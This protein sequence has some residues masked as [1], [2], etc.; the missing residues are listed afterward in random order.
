MKTREINFHEEISCPIAVEL[1]IKILGL[2]NVSNELKHNLKLWGEVSGD[3]GDRFSIDFK[4]EHYY[5]GYCYFIKTI[6]K[7]KIAIQ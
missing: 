2:K 7:V 1:L 4:A 3:T 5:N 6:E